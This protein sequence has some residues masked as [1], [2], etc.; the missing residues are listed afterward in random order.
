M[1]EP[2]PCRFMIPAACFIPRKT[3]RSSTPIVASKSSAAIWSMG[4]WTP[5]EPALL[6]RQSSRPKRRTVSSTIAATS[7][8]RLTSAW[9]YTARAPPSAGPAPLVL[10]IRQD[11]RGAL[12][13]E[14]A[15]GRFSDAAGTARD[16]RDLALKP[17]HARDGAVR[18]VVTS[19]SGR[20]PTVAAYPSP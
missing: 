7:A 1:I 3:P 17:L 19:R 12:L 18:L 5:A 15:H 16:E 9:T 11:H 14:Q 8:S 13:D 2:A 4:P 6:K 20:G 10:P